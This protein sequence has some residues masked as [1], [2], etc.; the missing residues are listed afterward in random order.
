M[1]WKHFLVYPEYFLS[2]EMHSKRRYKI[3]IWSVILGQ[4]ESFPNYMGSQYYPENFKCNLKFYE[5]R[6]FF[7]FLSPSGAFLNLKKNLGFLFR[8]KIAN[9]VSETRKIKL[10]R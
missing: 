1:H 8:Q 4:L 6:I 5:V 9:L 2:L 7:W 3:F 10:I